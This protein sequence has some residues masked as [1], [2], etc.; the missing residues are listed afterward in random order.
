MWALPWA[1]FVTLG[2]LFVW[3]WFQLKKKG[4]GEDNNIYHKS[5]LLNETKKV[6]FLAQN[7]VHSPPEL[8][9]SFAITVALVNTSF[10]EGEADL[11][12]PL[13]PTE[14][15]KFSFLVEYASS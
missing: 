9:L 6:K 14:L 15:W 7:M 12:L 1:I 13:H 4:G 5:L 8:F 3:F 11:L 2:K 10:T